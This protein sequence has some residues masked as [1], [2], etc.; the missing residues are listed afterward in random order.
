MR[1]MFLPLLTFLLAAAPVPSRPLAV[2]LPDTDGLFADAGQVSADP[3]NSNCL[4]C[5]SA[6]M[7]LNQPRLTRLQWGETLAKMRTA[8]HAPIDPADDAAILDWLV[9]HQG[10]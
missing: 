4:A 8:Y 7:V 6:A 5:H 10:N 3:I 1:P 2:E 9:A